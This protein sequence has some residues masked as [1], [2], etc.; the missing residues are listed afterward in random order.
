MTQ[1]LYCYVDETGQDTRGELFIVAV[2]IT[3]QERNQLRQA[4]EEIERDSRKGRRKWVKTKYDRRLAYIRQVVE[5]P[6]FAGK[7]NFAIYRDA[8]DHP[9]LTV[10]TIV[11]A[12]SA[13]GETDYKATVFIDGLPRSLERDVGLQLRRSGVRA[14]KVRGLKD[15]TDAL[16]R[17]ADAVCGFVRGA[18]QGQP[19]MRA[20]FGQAIQTGVLRDL[21]EKQKK[22]PWIGGTA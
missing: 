18:I 13:T 9:S 16:I 22:P 3:A 17:L 8:Q 2:V 6:I 11:R 10:Q 20:L 1:K 5:G 4:C 7:L 19:A 12:L 15:E 21:S 14:K